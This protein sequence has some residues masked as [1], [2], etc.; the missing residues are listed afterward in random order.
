VK[1]FGGYSRG[2][3]I[4]PGEANAPVI[5]PYL[6][7]IKPYLAVWPTCTCAPPV[8]FVFIFDRDT[9]SCLASLLTGSL[10]W[11]LRTACKTAACNGLFIITAP[12]RRFHKQ[13][14]GLGVCCK[15]PCKSKAVPSR[16]FCSSGGGWYGQLVVLVGSMLSLALKAVAT[17]KEKW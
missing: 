10:R 4:E 16:C 11:N 3:T 8:S 1:N 2:G 14:G 15:S 12:L 6:L 5:V 13:T 7:S 9:T 17:H